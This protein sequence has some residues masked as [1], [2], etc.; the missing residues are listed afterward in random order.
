MVIK[1]LFTFIP[2]FLHVKCHLMKYSIHTALYPFHNNQYNVF[3]ILSVCDKE[4]EKGNLQCNPHWPWTRDAFGLDYFPSAYLASMHHLVL[5]QFY[6][7]GFF[8]DLFYYFMWFWIVPECIM[9]TTCVLAWG[10][11]R[12]LEHLGLKL[13]TFVICYKGARNGTQSSY[14]SY[15]Y[16]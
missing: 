5:I 15:Q 11:K 4:G 3:L 12:V 6:F 14:E 7:L 9:C 8:L 16:S 10:K 1:F 13:Q 2:T